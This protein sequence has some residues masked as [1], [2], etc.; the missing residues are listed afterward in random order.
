MQSEEVQH[1]FVVKQ[2]M[3]VLAKCEAKGVKVEIVIQTML[4]SGVTML[5]TSQGQEG[6]AT[7]LESMAEAIRRGEISATEH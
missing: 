3:A 2:L 1:A 7:L 5:I 6:A 4:S